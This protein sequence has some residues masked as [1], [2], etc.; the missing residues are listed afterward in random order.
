MEPD[1][2][3]EIIATSISG[4]IRDWGKV[5]YIEPAFREHGWSRA[6]LWTA[7]SHAETRERTA[8]LACDGARVVVSA[9]GSGTFNAVLEG[10]VDSR[11]PL[12]E[13]RL[14]FLRKGS[15]DLIGKVLGMPDEVQA[16]VA[17]LAAA[18]EADCTVPCDVLRV[19]TAGRPSRHFVGYGGAELFGRIPHFTEN[20]FMKWYKGILGQ[21]FGDLGPFGTGLS[22]CLAERF[23][24]A[25]LTRKRHW[26]ILVDGEE[27]ASGAY[28]AL[29]LVNGHLGPQC[30]FSDDPLGSGRF[31]LFALRDL[32][33]HR[34]P[35]Q[36]RAAWKARILE[37]PERWGTEHHE[38]HDSLELDC[39]AR[40]F[41]LNVDGSTLDCRGS[42]RISRVDRVSL[43]C[44]RQPC[45]PGSG[46]E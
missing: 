4:S 32:G 14:G 1:T 45:P 39:A 33:L 25:P 13:F 3:V 36:V 23:L 42:V 43:L 16:G 38:I 28:Q 40:E 37:E 35:G 27:R 19:E 26:R 34:L 7:D 30:P 46:G 15:A 41:P 31:H 2:R 10:C 20:R 17:L 12:D 6:R 24:K 22:L 44:G 11:V 8:A 9:G 29:I 18:I 21:L 5:K